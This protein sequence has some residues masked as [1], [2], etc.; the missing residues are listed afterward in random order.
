MND[1]LI[2]V[3]SL[4]KFFPALMALVRYKK[5][6]PS[7]HPFL[8]AVWIGFFN[9]LVSTFMVYC[10][11]RYLGTQHTTVNNSIYILFEATLYAWQLRN[12]GTLK[13]RPL[14]FKCL[15]AGFIIF[16]LVECIAFQRIFYNNSVF[17][18]VYPVILVLMSLDSLNRVLTQERSSLLKNPIFLITVTFIIFFTYKTMVNIFGIYG[19]TQSLD[20]RVVIASIFMWLNGLTN[21]IFTFAIIWMPNKHRFSL[22]SA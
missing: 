7:Y 4:S 3:L 9:E 8:Y 16:W 1:R 5:I 6:H 10:G 17:R 2:D 15:I 13:G 22:L 20:F 21:V 11:Q 19:L 12:W 14:L 18:I